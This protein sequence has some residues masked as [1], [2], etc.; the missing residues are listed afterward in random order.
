MPKRTSNFDA[1][2]LIADREAFESHTANFRAEKVAPWTTYVYTG[3]MPK[4]FA[5]DLRDNLRA[6]NVEYIVFSYSTPIGWYH[7]REGW[8]IPRVSYSITTSRHQGI[9]RSGAAGYRGWRCAS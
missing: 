6:G 1:Y 7:K 4:A 8:I 9:L 2:S 5:D 3:H